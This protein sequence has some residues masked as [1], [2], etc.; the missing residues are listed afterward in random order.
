MNGFCC[1]RSGE[2]RESKLGPYYLGGVFDMENG[3]FEFQVFKGAVG[4]DVRESGGELLGRSVRREGFY[5]VWS[6]RA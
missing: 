2:A 3:Y 1:C 5:W 4:A 6:G